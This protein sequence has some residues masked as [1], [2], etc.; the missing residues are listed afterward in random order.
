M[1]R[2]LVWQTPL[3]PAEVREVLRENVDTRAGIPMFHVRGSPAFKRG[4]R[5]LAGS[6]NAFHFRVQVQPDFA[7]P[8]ATFC[9]AT[10]RPGNAGSTITVKFGFHPLA[11][12]VYVLGFGWTAFVAAMSVPLTESAPTRRLA[13][14]GAVLAV[15]AVAR[16]FARWRQRRDTPVLAAFLVRTLALVPDEAGQ[17]ASGARVAA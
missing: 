2:K 9:S 16:L 11:I 8:F 5:P 12:V 10:V 7:D 17:P 1:G 15:A 6:F 3:A 13:R 4:C 14:A